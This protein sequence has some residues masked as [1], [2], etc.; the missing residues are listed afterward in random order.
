VGG[1]AVG[2]DVQN[3]G[4]LSHA[5]FL[6]PLLLGHLDRQGIKGGLQFA[7]HSSER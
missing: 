4:C 1:A 2:L 5:A 6:M 3:P 7:L